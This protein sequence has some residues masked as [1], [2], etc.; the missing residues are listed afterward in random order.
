M[1]TATH[2]LTME[3]WAT[4]KTR[5][6][7]LV[8]LAFSPDFIETAKNRWLTDRGQDDEW[9]VGKDG[10]PILDVKKTVPWWRS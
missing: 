4:S 8:V 1:Y 3:V 10:R 7:V 6:A 5:G 2:C 9:T